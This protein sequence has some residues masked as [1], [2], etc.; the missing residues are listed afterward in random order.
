MPK[1]QAL[2]CCEG[3][4]NDVILLDLKFIAN[5]SCIVS[6][7]THVPSCLHVCRSRRIILGDPAFL[8]STEGVACQIRV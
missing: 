7:I 6:F 2:E 8:V 5:I 3:C 4:G 1:E